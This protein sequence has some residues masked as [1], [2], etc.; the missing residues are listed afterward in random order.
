MSRI[1]K[2]PITLPSGVQIQVSDKNLVT[3]K[4]PKGELQQ[5]VDPAIKVE[6]QEDKVV[7]NRQTDQKQHRAMH[8]LYRSLIQNMV[9]GVHE[10]YNEELELVGVGYR[11][12]TKGQLLELSLGYSHNV[13]FALPKEIKVE[14][15]AERGQTPRILLACHDKQLLGQVVAKI[16]SLR[17]PEPYKG[18]GIKVIGRQYRR[19][20][21]KTASK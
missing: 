3:A 21:G 2:L 19:K 16:V 5:A 11:A 7:V 4:G 6:V 10:G 15:K 1:G 17:K 12:N 13:A 9:K 8:G 18:K 20:A 14:T